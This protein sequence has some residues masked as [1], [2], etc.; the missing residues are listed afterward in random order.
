MQNNNIMVVIG[1]HDWTLKAAHLA[2]AVALS[3]CGEVLLLKMIAV[4]HPIL[5]GTDL[6]YMDLTVQDQQ[7]ITEYERIVARYGVRVEGCI[8]QY[9]GYVSGLIDAAGQFHASIVF[10]LPPRRPFAFQHR[11][12]VWRLGKGLA[13]H[14]RRLY[15]LEPIGGE[16]EGTP[17]FVSDVQ[18]EALL[19]ASVPEKQTIHPLEMPGLH[20][21]QG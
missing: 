14:D 7:Q 2:S 6:G 3:R 9:S 16:A 21:K 13:R 4:R 1:E 18:P 12:D 5:L 17:Y 10:A 20:H 8:F 11:L 15:T 19:P